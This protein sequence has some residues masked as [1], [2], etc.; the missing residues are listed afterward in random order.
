MK[1]T[2][3]GVNYNVILVNHSFH[4]ADLQGYINRSNRISIDKLNN[5]LTSIRNIPSTATIG[6]RIVLPKTI[7][8]SPFSKG[9]R[10]FSPPNINITFLAPNQGEKAYIL[11]RVSEEEEVFLKMTNKDKDFISEKVLADLKSQNLDFISIIEV[12]KMDILFSIRESISS[13][14]RKQEEEINNYKESMVE[15]IELLHSSF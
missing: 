12:L 13:N 11:D 10:V 6:L 7:D 3:F 4:E 15:A 14:L 8:Y 2:I 5:F 9:K 1:L